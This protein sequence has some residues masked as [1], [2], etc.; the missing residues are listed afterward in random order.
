MDGAY[1]AGFPTHFGTGTE[2]YYGW[3]GGKVP[4]REDVFSH[5]F[6][7]NVSVGST[8]ED[9]PRGFNICTRIRALDAIPFE[10]RLRFDMEA[11]LAPGLTK[12]AVFGN[13]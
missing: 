4:R 3:A 10:H 12:P 2:D 1:D 13:A 7:A 6:L 9:N 11:L 8:G 5:P